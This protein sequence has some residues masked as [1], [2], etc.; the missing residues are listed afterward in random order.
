MLLCTL[1]RANLAYILARLSCCALVV[2]GF[3]GCAQPDEYLKVGD[4]II[5]ADTIDKIA[6]KLQLSFKEYGDATLRS[7]LLMNGL[8]EAELLHQ[9]NPHES[10]SALAEIARLHAVAIKYKPR[11]LSAEQLRGFDHMSKTSAPTPSQFGAGIAAAVAELGNDQ[12]S[13]PFKTSTGWAIA[14]LHSRQPGQTSTASITVEV[15]SIAVGNQSDYT[16]NL[17]LWQSSPLDGSDRLISCL[18]F[19][20]R[21]NPKREKNDN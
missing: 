11:A 12:W 4:T 7:H 14:Y 2:S 13:R 18:P 21:N 10:R 5:Y 9:S 3:V 17:Y 15:I 20:F 1:T 8:A 16:N 6:E 19:E